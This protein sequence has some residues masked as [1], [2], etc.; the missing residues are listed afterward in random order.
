MIEQVHFHSSLPVISS[1]AL[2]RTGQTFYV[3][4]PHK[5]LHGSISVITIIIKSKVVHFRRNCPIGDQEFFKCLFI[6]LYL[7]S[8]EISLRCFVYQPSD[9]DSRNYDSFPNHACASRDSNFHVHHQNGWSC[10]PPW[11]L[12]SLRNG[13]DSWIQPPMLRRFPLPAWH[14]WFNREHISVN[15]ASICAWNIQTKL[16]MMGLCNF[17]VLRIHMSGYIWPNSSSYCSTY[18]KIFSCVSEL[19]YFSLL[20]E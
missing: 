5:R 7:L 3:Y 18:G 20:N 17:G 19:I 2:N 8:V 12:K 16:C 9:N 4:S 15:Y 1:L 11:T 10:N 6:K 13:S 14:K